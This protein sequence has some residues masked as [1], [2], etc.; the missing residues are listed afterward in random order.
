MVKK[1]LVNSL[2]PFLLLLLLSLNIQAKVD[3]FRTGAQMGQGTV[4]DSF[5]LGASFV[6]LDT[7]SDVIVSYL[8]KSAAWEGKLYFMIPDIKDSAYY[9]FTNKPENHPNEP[10]RVNITKIFKLKANTR[11]YF[12]YDTK[13]F[14]V[15]PLNPKYTGENVS[16][17]DLY[18]S[19]DTHLWKGQSG[20]RRW[21]TAG[22]I[23]DANGDPTDSAE[24]TFE[25]NPNG[26][27]DYNDIIFRV[28]GLGLNFEVIPVLVT[29]GQDQQFNVAENS[30]EGTKVGKIIVN[31]TNSSLVTT[32]II[33]NVPEFEV[34]PSDPFEITVA[35]GANL[36]A[37]IKDSYLLTIVA[38]SGTGAKAISDTSNIIIIITELTE[39]IDNSNILSNALILRTIVNGSDLTIRGLPANS[40]NLKIIN[41]KGQNVIEKENEVLSIID[42]SPISS[43]IYFISI[44]TNNK[45]WFTKIYKK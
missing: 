31:T 42:I 38:I 9:L 19:N 17:T 5:F 3:F 39:T 1:Y 11:I 24:F 43:G 45:K 21:S 15:T 29:I 16:G 20:D 36:D 14:N 37:N 7:T 25:D 23:K 18:V 34:S 35:N 30:P 28:K 41:S 10:S 13:K 22:R 8:S 32:K 2:S 40:Y 12:R 33:N 6:Y 26:D 44:I 4:A 27:F